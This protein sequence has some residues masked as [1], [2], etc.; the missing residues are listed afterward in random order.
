M[1]VKIDTKEMFHVICIEE[2]ILSANMSADLSK[3]ATSQYGSKGLGN[4][5]LTDL[6]GI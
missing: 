1:R 5:P 4:S 6:M 3:S 2:E